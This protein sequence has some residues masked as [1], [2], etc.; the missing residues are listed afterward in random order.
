MT[1]RATA[2]RIEK[3]WKGWHDR[4][5][6]IFG[7]LST[8]FTGEL[9]YAHRCCD[10]NLITHVEFCLHKIDVSGWG[11]GSSFSIFYWLLICKD[12]YEFELKHCVH[13][14]PWICCYAAY[15][16][17]CIRCQYAIDFYLVELD[18]GFPMLF[19]ATATVRLSL[20]IT[21]RLSVICAYIVI[22]DCEIVLIFLG[23]I[24]LLF[25]NPWF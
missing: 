2:K 1:D 20:L 18:A 12:T 5:I 25:L 3:T 8:S 7:S 21:C 15:T 4:I 23:K 19:S 17:R 13:T 24:K 10:V 22:N 6:L 11:K 9:V 16:A 14:R